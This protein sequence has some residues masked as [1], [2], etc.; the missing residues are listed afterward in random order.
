MLGVLIV[1]VKDRSSSALAILSFAPRDLELTH[2]AI[3]EERGGIFGVAQVNVRARD[4]ELLKLFV[5][6]TALRRGV[7]RTLFSWA[8]DVAGKMNA[9]RM[10]IEADPE[11]AGFYREMGARD[12][13]EAP[14]GSLPGRMLPRLSFDVAQ[15]ATEARGRVCAS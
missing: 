10:I 9:R 11:A 6:P 7:G 12:A 5:E 2:V 15:R 4:A 1:K 14:S 13:G 3:A 8:T